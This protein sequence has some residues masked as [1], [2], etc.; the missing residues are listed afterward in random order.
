MLYHKYQKSTH[1]LHTGDGLDILFTSEIPFFFF[2]L[3][4][5]NDKRRMFY[6]SKWETSGTSVWCRVS[7]LISRLPTE[8]SL[9]LLT[10][11]EYLDY[12]F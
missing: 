4:D 9:S 2:F 1:W 10:T 5:L 12:E 3:K 6:L 7:L 8:A 11:S